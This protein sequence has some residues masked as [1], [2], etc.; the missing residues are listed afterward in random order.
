MAPSQNALAIF[1]R[2]M[3][4]SMR[5]FPPDK[6]ANAAKD[7][8]D[9]RV[10]VGT[11]KA[12]FTKLRYIRLRV[13]E[14][15]RKAAMTRATNKGTREQAALSEKKKVE[16]K[17]EAEKKK[18]KATAMTAVRSD[19]E[20]SCD[21]DNDDH[22]NDDD[23]SYDDQFTVESILE[24]SGNGRSRRYKLKWVGHVEPTWEPTNNIDLRVS[25]ISYALGPGLISWAGAGPP[26][27]GLSQH[28]TVLYGPPPSS[29]GGGHS[30]R[31]VSDSVL[32]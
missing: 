10:T 16:D 24:H 8:N 6:L 3:G 27:G 1:E 11:L 19:E 32:T 13:L 14:G 25:H 4:S 2:E 20:E 30:V 7:I 31:H 22:W 23:N 28:P 21:N 9:S 29:D 18:R 12:H 5:P 26:R 17:K 15:R